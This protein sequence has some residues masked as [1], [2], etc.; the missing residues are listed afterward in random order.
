MLNFLVKIA[1]S[2]ALLSTFA[3]ANDIEEDARLDTV[4]I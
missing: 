3:V 1:V 4:I 2:V